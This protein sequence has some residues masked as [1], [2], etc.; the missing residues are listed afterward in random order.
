MLITQLNIIVFLNI[1]ILCIITYFQI[2]TQNVASVD[3][4]GTVTTPIKIKLLDHL[5]IPKFVKNNKSFEEIVDNRS[6]QLL[7]QI[8]AS[9]KKLAVMYSGGIDSTVIMCSI[10]KNWPKENVSCLMF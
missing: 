6:L 7:E 2:F 5:K 1:A 3:R 9:N 8:K 10:V 4:T